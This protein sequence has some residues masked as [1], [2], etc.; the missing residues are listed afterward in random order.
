[1]TAPRCSSKNQTWEKEYA[2]R[3]TRRHLGV[4]VSIYCIWLG[5]LA[6]LAASR[7]WLGPLQ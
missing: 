3:V 1:M 5:F 7:W 4:T 6:A 2:P